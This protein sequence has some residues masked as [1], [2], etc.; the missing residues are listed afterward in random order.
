MRHVAL[1]GQYLAGPRHVGVVALDLGVGDADEVDENAPT[2]AVEGQCVFVVALAQHQLGAHA[3]HLL[4]RP[5]PELNAAVLVDHQSGIGQEV[6]DVG[7]APFRLAQRRLGEL[8]GRDVA[9][10]GLDHP[11]AVEL[12][13][14]EQDVGGKDIAVEAAVQPFEAGR[15]AAV[16]H[17]AVRLGGIG[18]VAAIGLDRRR[19]VRR[20][21]TE[22]V[23][24][25]GEAKQFERTGVA[26]EKAALVVEDDGVARRL[27][28]R[29]EKLLAR[30]HPGV[31]DLQLLLAAVGAP[32]QILLTALALGDV[33]EITLI[34]DHR[35]P[36][37]VHGE[38]GIADPKCGA[39]RAPGKKV[40][41]ADAVAAGHQ[42]KPAGAGAGIGINFCVGCGQQ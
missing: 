35:P 27:E 8:A 9:H 19:D 3:G 38:G 36:G 23:L 20:L 2:A 29:L 24:L 4:Q 17:P 18:G 11:L 16:R 13:R 5:V 14:G 25:V 6:D 12:E 42:L 34:A 28:H 32:D 15:T 7:H 1:P 37:V 22:K 31:A 33:L 21:E 30:R 26:V 41:T 39:I 10:G 40:E